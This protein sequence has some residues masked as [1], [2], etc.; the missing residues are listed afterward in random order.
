[1]RKCSVLQLATIVA[2][3]L[4]SSSNARAADDLNW[5]CPKAGTVFRTDI[6]KW[7]A[8]GPGDPASLA[9]HYIRDGVDKPRYSGIFAE[10]SRVLTA[11]EST[12]FW[13][14]K[15]GTFV[16][17]LVQNHNGIGAFNESIRVSGPEM[18]TVPAGTFETMRIEFWE[19]FASGGIRGA[20]YD[21]TETFY[22]SPLL[23]FPVKHTKKVAE[24]FADRIAANWDL[25]SIETE[26]Q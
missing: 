6:G 19:A 25:L 8:F 12:G 14:L 2:G 22:W 11:P 16:S 4:A 13:P 23:H 24:G 20:G 17:F 26:K 21:V 1:M 7:A 5:A 3:L 18:V 9:C 10:G 15:S